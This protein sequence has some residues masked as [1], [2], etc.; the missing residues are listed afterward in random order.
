MAGLELV[1]HLLEENQSYH[2]PNYSHINKWMFAGRGDLLPDEVLAGLEPPVEAE[3]R[4]GGRVWEH[5]DPPLPLP[6]P[7]CKIRDSGQSGWCYHSVES[8]LG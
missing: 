3:Y 7:P 8:T 6:S 4:L 2:L 5:K 1:Q